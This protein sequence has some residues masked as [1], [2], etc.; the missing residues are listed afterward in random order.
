MG[1]TETGNTNYFFVISGVPRDFFPAVAYRRSKQFASER[2][3][4]IRCPY[5]ARQ[6]IVINASTK[7]ELYRYPKKMEVSCHE[8]RKCH[9]CH[10]TVGIIFKTL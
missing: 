4:I 7:I 2:Q 6:L 3:K 9:A 10:E 1:E 5:C 8:Y